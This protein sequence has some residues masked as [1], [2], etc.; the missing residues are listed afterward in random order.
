MPAIAADGTKPP[1]AKEE[2]L[3]IRYL[4]NL[5]K[6]YQQFKVLLRKIPSRAYLKFISLNIQRDTY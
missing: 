2:N 1:I 6:Y 5:L 3:Y 4:I